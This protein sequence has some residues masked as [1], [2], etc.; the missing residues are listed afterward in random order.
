MKPV[1]RWVPWIAVALA[2]LAVFTGFS[3]RRELAGLRREVA[4]LREQARTT[5]EAQRRIE[6]ELAALGTAVELFFVDETPT[7]IRLAPEKRRIIASDV[8]AGVMLELIKGP[9]PGSRLRPSLPRD[10]VLNGVKIRGGIA[11]VDLSGGITRL[12]VGSEG[13]AAVVGS[14][15]RTMT[16]LPGVK[17][18]Q[19]LV[20][21][22]EVE[23]LAG[24]VDVSVPLSPG[25]FQ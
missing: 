9:R 1:E 14:I 6:E 10:T 15:V 20:N 2:A 8:P 16:G 18:V 22:S 17:Q 19:I 11:Y 21:G 25:Q 12:N 3:A 5:N 7:A 13:E 4:N 23:T 24:H